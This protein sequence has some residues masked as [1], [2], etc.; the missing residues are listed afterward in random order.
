MYI[1]A[2]LCLGCTQLQFLLNTSLQNTYMHSLVLE[3]ALE[4][5][6]YACKNA[7]LPTIGLIRSVNCI[8]SIGFAFSRSLS[9]NLWNCSSDSVATLVALVQSGVVV[10]GDQLLCANSTLVADIVIEGT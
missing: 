9:F 4:I 8:V 1:H 3:C 5:P 10:N 2:D 7:P 6:K